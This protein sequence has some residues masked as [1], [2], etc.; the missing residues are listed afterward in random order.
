MPLSFFHVL[1]TAAFVLQQKQ[2][3]ATETAWPATPKIVTIWPVTK[4]VCR[5]LGYVIAEVIFPHQTENSP[6]ERS[7]PLLKT[8]PQPTKA[9]RRL[10]TGRSSIDTCESVR[11]LMNH[12]KC[13][14]ILDTDQLHIL[15]TSNTYIHEEVLRKHG[16]PNT[17]RNRNTHGQRHS[18]F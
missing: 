3:I 18:P 4:K 13:T 14:Q 17:E 16:V 6:R 5:P 1:Y 11:E 9:W 2:T 12:T 7:C 8:L 10:Y 15:C